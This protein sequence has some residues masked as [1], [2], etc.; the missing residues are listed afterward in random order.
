MRR[1]KKILTAY[2]WRS[3]MRLTLEVCPARASIWGSPRPASFLLPWRAEFLRVNPPQCVHG[4]PV[5]VLPSVKL[6]ME[7]VVYL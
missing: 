6:A 4:F 3:K 5:D 1:L 7:T 2:S